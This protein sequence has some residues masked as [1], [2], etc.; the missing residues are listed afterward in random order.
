MHQIS[1]LQHSGKCHCDCPDRPKSAHF[2]LKSMFDVLV[3]QMSGK[4][5][6]KPKKNFP[7]PKL[8]VLGR[9]WKF[10]A[11]FNIDVIGNIWDSTDPCQNIPNRCPVRWGTQSGYFQR[12]PGISISAYLQLTG[13]E[14]KGAYLCSKILSKIFFIKFGLNP[15]IWTQF[16]RSK[17]IFKDFLVKDKIRNFSTPDQKNFEKFFFLVGRR[18]KKNFFF[19]NQ[20]YT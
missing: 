16:Q 1:F 12:P 20:L 3:G 18:P 4:F 15:P 10:E 5:G 11:I 14:T 7:G 8:A 19:K 13:P 17:V 6:Q 2:G 9:K